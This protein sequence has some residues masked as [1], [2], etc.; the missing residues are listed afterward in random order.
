MKVL[1]ELCDVLEE[2]LEE[3]VKSARANGMSPDELVNAYKAV[4]IVKD[5]ETIK[6]MKEADFSGYS[7]DGNYSNRMMPYYASYDDDYSMARGRGSNAMRDGRGRYSRDDEKEHLMKEM[8]NMK[9]QL[10]QMQR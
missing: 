7:K 4:D 1:Y 9:R 6:A 3:I 2:E 8:E 10:E 5:I